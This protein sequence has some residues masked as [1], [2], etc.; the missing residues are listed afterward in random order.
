MEKILTVLAYTA[1]T[2]D[3]TG[4]MARKFMRCTVSTGTG[5]LTDDLPRG[6]RLW[7][8]ALH[9]CTPSLYL[10]EMSYAEIVKD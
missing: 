7:A 10:K 3:C 4:V 1:I 8:S 5:T 9:N 2:Q 6:S